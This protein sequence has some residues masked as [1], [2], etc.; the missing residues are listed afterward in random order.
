M[1]FNGLL[2]LVCKQ[3][4][5][6]HTHRLATL[7]SVV[8]GA[9]TFVCHSPAEKGGWGGSPH[10]KKGKDYF[11]GRIGEVLFGCHQPACRCVLKRHVARGV[12]A[13]LLFAL[14][15][16]ESVLDERPKG[17][18]KKKKGPSASTAHRMYFGVYFSVG[19]APIAAYVCAGTATTISLDQAAVFIFRLLRACISFLS[20]ARGECTDAFFFVF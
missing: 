18:L 5:A 17:H 12:Q 14:L 10:K 15:P 7:E 19:I 3:K 1:F 20:C 16:L 13:P 11:E 4:N 9:W 2:P 8:S 6:A